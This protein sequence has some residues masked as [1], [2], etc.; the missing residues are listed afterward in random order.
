ML[1][2][3]CITINNDFL[4]DIVISKL[5]DCDCVVCH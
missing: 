3:H 1:E 2:E 5:N 4:N